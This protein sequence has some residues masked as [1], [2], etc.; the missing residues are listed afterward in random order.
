MDAATLAT[1]MMSLGVVFGWQA[2][3]DDQEKY[4]AI[5]Q[6]DPELADL[7]AR[8]GAVPVAVEIPPEI[9]PIGRIRIVVG[10][11]DLPRERLVT[12]M[13]PVAET[14]GDSIQLTQYNQPAAGAPA[15]RYGGA[16]S[17]AFD[18]YAK[19][20]AGSSAA[21]QTP[22]TPGLQP[23]NPWT[24]SYQRASEDLRNAYQQAQQQTQTSTQA[25]A[26][27]QAAGLENQLRG[28]AGD[29]L[30][31]AQQAVDPAQSQNSGPTIDQLFGNG[32]T[33]PRTTAPPWNTNNYTQ[34]PG[35]QNLDNSTPS[36]APRPLERI[37]D[38]LGRAVEPFRDGVERVDDRLRGAAENVSDRT[39]QLFDNLGRPIRSLADRQRSILTGRNDSPA[40]AATNPGVDP[41]FTTPTPNPY[42]Q[43]T[44]PYSNDG[45]AGSYQP[46][47]VDAPSDYRSAPPRRDPRNDGQLAADRQQD[48]SDWGATRG[49]A[50]PWPEVPQ[51]RP[52][53][54][55][56][57]GNDWGQSRWDLAERNA[58]GG[59]QQGRASRGDAGGNSADR[60]PQLVGSS[61]QPATPTIERQM[62]AG[63]AT[64]PVEA[65]ADQLLRFPSDP[66]GLDLSNNATP[67]LDPG[68]TTSPFDTPLGGRP[69]A[70]DLGWGEH[71]VM[72]TD[73]PT[74]AS[75]APDGGQ[76]VAGPGQQAPAADTEEQS[77]SPWGI[78]LA[79]IL[80][81]G[82]F[83]G[84]VYLFWSY[85]DV[86]NKYSSLI[87]KS[88]R[89]VGSRFATV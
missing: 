34:N 27:Q 22:T 88:A 38:N 86:R 50:Q 16:A 53:T 2:M 26:Q 54:D 20:I 66:V 13:K 3:P 65:V 42:G 73:P 58:S 85:L 1:A 25:W 45:G 46:S 47:R 70:A 71:P 33:A 75:A 89:S 40:P 67:G 79:W 4:E 60:G 35:S 72:S 12:A 8:G 6:L 24:Q 36:T 83:A 63:P 64:A 31:R 68:A 18:P 55:R 32:S 74:N 51:S 11:G 84:N 77:A 15:S 59:S 62:L 43:R 76:Q 56:G 52:A 14:P 48:D 57:N 78:L 44:G 37:G 28:A 5:V 29:A 82:S 49:S 7:L 19:P 39:R 41:R 17:T 81:S 21:G 61:G 23:G 69:T 30:N 10:Q 9:Q 80:L 87:R